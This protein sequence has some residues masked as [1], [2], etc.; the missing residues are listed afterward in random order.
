MKT[1]DYVPSSIGAM[2]GAVIACIG[3]L[4][5]FDIVRAIAL[6]PDF[7]LLPHFG[8]QG[9]ATQASLFQT[10][11]L[12]LICSVACLPVGWFVGGWIASKLA[13]KFRSQ[14]AEMLGGL[15]GGMVPLILIGLWGWHKVNSP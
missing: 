6:W 4:F 9:S 5:V 3:G 10:P 14:R 2:L 13:G 1:P 11:K 15:I 7:R 8:G 12:S